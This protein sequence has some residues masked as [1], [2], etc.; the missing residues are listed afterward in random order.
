MALKNMYN[1]CDDHSANLVTINQ[2]EKMLNIRPYT[3]KELLL[4][5]ASLGDFL[6]QD[7]FVHVVDEAVETMDLTPYYG[8]IS[9]VGNPAYDPALMIKILFYGYATKSYSSRNIDDKLHKDVAFIFLAGMQKPDFRTIS[10]FRKDNLA[11]LKSSFVEIVQICHRLGL[12]KF[13]EIS[14][15]SKVMKANASGEN[16]Y[17]EKELI[18]EQ[19]EIEKLIQA[20]LEKA[21]QTDLQEDEKHGHDRGGNELPEDIGKKEDRIEKMKKIKEQLKMAQE[22]LKKSDEKK[23]NLTDSDARFQKDKSRIIPGY[24]AQIGVDSQRQII[25]AN[26]VTNN[27][28]DAPQLV[29]MVEKVLENVKELQRQK[30]SEREQR[31]NLIHILADAGYSSGKNLSELEKEPYKQ[32]VESY[33]P[34]TNYANRERGKGYNKD[35]P[36]HRSKFIYNQKENSFTCPA[37]KILHFIGQHDSHGVLCDVYENTKDC[38]RCPYYGECTTSKTGRRIQVSEYQP[39]IDQMRQKLSTQDGKRIYALRKIT[40]EPVFGNLAQNLG[41]RGFLLRGLEKVSGEFSLMCIAHNLLKIARHLRGVGKTLHQALNG[42]Q[43][44][45][46]ADTS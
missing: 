40:V 19:A 2:E 25:V 17:D 45:P 11:L 10:D 13:G 24:R 9:P 26:D 46:L 35:S 43:L 6:P 18:E 7:D 5:P 27:Q 8:K 42:L 4:F 12:T 3:N 29:P 36:F 30:L 21:N 23:I 28:N 31:K 14:L 44:S 15:D 33:I 16:T 39:L 22:N 41:F 20:Y 1:I 38:K 32:K 34:D 37:G